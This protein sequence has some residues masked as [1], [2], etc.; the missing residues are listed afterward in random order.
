PGRGGAP[1]GQ[2]SWCSLRRC[3]GRGPCG[4]AAPPGLRCGRVVRTRSRVHVLRP[5]VLARA[6]ARPLARH[7]HTADEQLA[8]PDAPGLLALQRA[9]EALL[10]ER[11]E[12]YTSE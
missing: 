5:R 1:G 6:A 11:S 8:A 7:D 4:G 12:E 3:G 2:R 10:A 9:G